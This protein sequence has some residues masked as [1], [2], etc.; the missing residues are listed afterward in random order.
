LRSFV[1]DV[2]SYISIS[3]RSWCVDDLRDPMKTTEHKF[4]HFPSRSFR[5]V[6][7]SGGYGFSIMTVSELSGRFSAVY[8]L[9]MAASRWSLVANLGL[10]SSTAYYAEYIN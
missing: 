4:D 10:S 6:D 9:D 2:N 8:R 5:G 3:A 7:C 1:L